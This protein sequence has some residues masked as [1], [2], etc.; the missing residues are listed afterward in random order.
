LARSLAVTKGCSVPVFVLLCSLFN[1]LLYQWPLFKMALSSRTELD[2]HAALALGTLFV[3]QL[4]VSLAILGLVAIVSIRLLKVVCV[5]F[6]IGNSIALYFILQYGVTLDATMIGNILNTN[7]AEASEL[8]HVKLMAYLLALGLIPALVIF[9]MRIKRSSRLSTGLYLMASLLVGVGWLYGN[10]QSW[11]WIDKNAKQFGGLI[12]PWSYVINPVRYL[13]QEASRN[14]VVE[15]LPELTST[16]KK[17]AIVV[18]VIGES[19]RAQNFSLYGYKRQTNPLLSQRSAPS[20]VALAGANSC[21]TYTTASLRCMLSYR[22]RET[23]SSNDEP[24]PSYLL[25]HGVEVL[26]RTNNFGEPAIR[27][28][29]YERANDLRKQCTG[30]CKKLEFDEVL[31][32]GLEEQ[33]KSATDSL[34]TLVV[35]HQAGSHGPQYDKKYPAEFERFKPACKTVELQ[36]CSNEE[37]VNAYDNTI[38]Y[39]DFVLDRI[40]TLLSSIKDTASVLIYM[41]DHGESLGE[42]GLYLHGV[43]M[44]IAPEVQTSVPLFVWRSEE[45]LR[46]HGVPMQSAPEAAVGMSHDVVFHSVLGALGVTSNIYRPQQDV[47]RAT[48][49]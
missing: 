29:R 40:I 49:R 21:S 8:I 28:S 13:S 33:L 14:R 42:K 6:A 44:A 23:L 12:L 32:H 39:T 38:L 4:L 15:L 10:S 5:I 43:P 25:R 7:I 36:K 18:L 16:D 34:K 48:A 24:L 45:F 11:L 2:G 20:F 3:L 19:A 9:S 31:L 35:L 30:D 17:R 41:S 1:A 46:R 37:L 26:W 22:G 27:T 47:F